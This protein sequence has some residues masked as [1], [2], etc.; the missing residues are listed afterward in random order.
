VENTGVMP[1]CNIKAIKY[2]DG[3]VVATTSKLERVGSS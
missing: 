2:R 1:E 3:D